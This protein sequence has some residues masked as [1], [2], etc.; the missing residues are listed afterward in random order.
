MKLINIKLLIL[1]ETWNIIIILNDFII[2]CFWKYLK[3]RYKIIY[4]SFYV[5][6]LL[7]IFIL[8]L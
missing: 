4:K 5:L 7:F 8:F 6:K 3:I 2:I 1:K